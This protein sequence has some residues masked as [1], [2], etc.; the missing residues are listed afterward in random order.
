MGRTDR[1]MIMQLVSAIG[2]G[3]GERER[4]QTLKDKMRKEKLK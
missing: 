1:W 2:G 3:I 4:A